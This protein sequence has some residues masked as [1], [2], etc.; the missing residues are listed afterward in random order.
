[1]GFKLLGAENVVAVILVQVFFCSD[2]VGNLPP[3]VA[4]LQH[5]FIVDQQRHWPP[6]STVVFMVI[7]EL[8]RKLH[9]GTT[10]E[11]IPLSLVNYGF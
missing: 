9:M 7:E 5:L 4:K 6:I 2:V 1:M 8:Q 3:Y 10:W 11:V